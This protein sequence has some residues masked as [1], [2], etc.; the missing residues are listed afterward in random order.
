MHAPLSCNN[1]ATGFK[2]MVT[3]CAGD[4][5]RMSEEIEFDRQVIV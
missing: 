1:Q 4:V 2:Q 5:L 3:K